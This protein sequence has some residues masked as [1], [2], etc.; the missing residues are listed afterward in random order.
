MAWVKL[1]DQFADHPKVAQAGP[2]AAWMHVKALVYCG[3]Y[4]TDGFI[5]RAIAHTLVDWASAGIMVDTGGNA[6]AGSC[7]TPTCA[8]LA[9]LLID[10][11][12][13]EDAEGG[14]QIHD[15]LEHNPP[16][17]K[18]KAERDA[19]K[20]RKAAGRARQGRNEKTGR[21]E[22][23][24]VSARTSDRN[25]PGQ[26]PD[27]RPE[28]ARNPGH[29]PP[30]PSPSPD[31]LQKDRAREPVADD[32]IK[33]V[34]DAEPLLARVDTRRLADN[35]RADTITCGWS[36]KRI[37][38]CLPRALESLRLSRDP[39]LNPIRFVVMAVRQLA[40]PGA[41][42]TQ[43]A[44]DDVKSK[45]RTEQAAATVEK[46]QASKG[47][48]DDGFAAREL[49]AMEQTEREARERSRRGAGEASAGDLFASRKGAA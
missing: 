17:A 18:V 43:D 28:S 24:P 36:D 44:A 6:F 30:V 37:V 22:S 45:W 34:L 3:R 12:L 15:Y 4:L 39:N 46:Y 10:V 38:Q 23:L 7:D 5:P 27:V 19:E 41:L 40:K 2:L 8:A 32:A 26:P 33:S 13:W 29:V 1:D 31:S 16:A 48:S 47:D 49:A 11:G 21:I 20:A 25:P 14:Y 42:E 9:D 35:L